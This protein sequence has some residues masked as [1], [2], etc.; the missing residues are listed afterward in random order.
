M[1]ILVAELVVG[2]LV[3]PSQQQAVKMENLP[4][5]VSKTFRRTWVAEA[6]QKGAQP[7]SPGEEFSG[8]LLRNICSELVNV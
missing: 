2:L 1:H 6:L 5:S 3:G 7:L 8:S 4:N